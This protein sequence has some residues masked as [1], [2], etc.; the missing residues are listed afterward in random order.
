MSLCLFNKQM[1]YTSKKIS[2][3]IIIVTKLQIYIHK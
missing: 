1:A 3:L 2:G